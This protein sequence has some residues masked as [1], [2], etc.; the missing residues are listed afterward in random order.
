MLDKRGVITSTKTDFI[1][2]TAFSGFVLSPGPSL[3]I[4]QRGA[5]GLNN[6]SWHVRDIMPTLAPTAWAQ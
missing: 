1:L 4:A 5:T 3:F 2:M 6:V